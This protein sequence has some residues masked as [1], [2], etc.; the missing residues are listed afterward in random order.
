MVVVVVVV[1]V[2]LAIIIIIIISSS[3][4]CRSRNRVI[5][6]GITLLAEFHYFGSGTDPISLLI[7]LWCFRAT[8]SGIQIKF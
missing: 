5:F 2:I 1:V 7:L 8:C 4:S 3:S 6:L